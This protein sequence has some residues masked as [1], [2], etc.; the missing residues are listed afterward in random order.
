[1]FI[2]F[3]CLV[4]GVII[5]VLINNSSR[6]PS[7]TS[8]EIID[9]FKRSAEFSRMMDEYADYKI[10]DAKRTGVLDSAVVTK[11]SFVNI[12]TLGVNITEKTN[13][14]EL[15]YT[16]VQF[17]DDSAGNVS[18]EEIAKFK[19][20]KIPSEWLRPLKEP[21]SINRFTGKKVVITGVF[22]F[23]RIALAELLWKSGADL[24]T[25]INAKTDF[26]I[27]GDNAGWRKCEQIE[28]LGVAC[29]S[30]EEI[31]EDFPEL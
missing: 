24:D 1:M 28:E 26:V 15:D 12:N 9:E 16:G 5:G 25:A 17:Y 10:S 23:D 14:P 18:R 4:I 22:S 20:N 21:T 27:K 31:L 8:Q 3:I 11:Q 7:R 13:R 2:G 19:E 6:A 30:E 29:I